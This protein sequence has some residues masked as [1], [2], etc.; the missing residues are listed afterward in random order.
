MELQTYYWIGFFVFVFIMLV[1]DLGVFNKKAHEI[2]VK[3][4]MIWSGVWISMAMVFNGIIYL[5]FGSEKALE[6]LTGYVIEK[7]LSVDN[8]FVFIMIFSYFQIK[9]IYQH[10]ILFWG[11]I[12]ALVMRAMFIF[13]GIKMI[14]NFHW[15]IYVFG[16]FLIITGVKMLFESKEEI[17][18]EEK[19]IVKLLKR[20]IPI[21][22]HKDDGKFFTIINAKKFATPL[23]VALV[24]IEFTDLIFA[25]DSIPAILAISNDMFIVYTSNI[26][27]ILGLRSLYFALSGMMGNFTYLK[28]GLSG[29]LSFVGMK[30]LISG[31][32]TFPILLSLG[33]II[34]FLVLSVL[35][36]YVFPPK[37]I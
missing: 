23:F 18:L 21:S 28:Y 1:L 13:A 14:E 25:V 5:G 24:M 10:K 37:K 19:A 9:K 3:E 16:V 7:S 20:I 11:I 32:Y 2:K 31:Y 17:D 15:I 8:L 27:A 12:G 33:I 30:M 6:F 4:A 29:V 22:K 35:A 26:F 36:S 34:G